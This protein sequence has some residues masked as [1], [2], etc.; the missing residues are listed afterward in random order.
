LADRGVRSLVHL[1]NCA[2]TARVLNLL[3]IWRAHKDDPQYTSNPFFQNSRLNRAMILKHRLRRDEADLFEQPRLNATKIVFAVDPNDLKIG[4]QYAFIGQKNFQETVRQLAGHNIKQMET[5][6]IPLLTLLDELP[7]LDPFLLREELRRN[8]YNP[9]ACYLQLSDADQ[10]RIF[11]FVHAEVEPL[12]RKSLGNQQG[13][14]RQ[15]SKLVE[16]IL[17]NTIDAEMQ[18]LRTVLGLTQ[19][20]FAEGIFCWK[21]FLYYKWVYNLAASSAPRVIDTISSIRPIGSM[22]AKMRDQL[23]GMIRGVVE[24]ICVSIKGISTLLDVYD[25]AYKGLTES[26]NPAA[27]RDFLLKAPSLF[28]Q[29]GGLLGVLQHVITFCDFRFPPNK[30]PMVSPEELFDI[31]SD[32]EI[33]FSCTTTR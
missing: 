5:H 19:E 6:D 14:D 27:F 12:V 15:T 13:V 20:A 32:F 18:P 4:G 16:K 22:D 29:L 21:G 23:Q 30:R 25:T 3:T 1:Q 33:Q 8:G 10:E 31:F 17:S 7:S 2:S 24:N 26:A 28:V 9:G 11:A